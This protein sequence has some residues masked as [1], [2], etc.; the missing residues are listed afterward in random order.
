MSSPLKTRSKTRIKQHPNSI[1]YSVKAKGKPITSLAYPAQ[2][3]DSPLF[4]PGPGG[5][6]PGGLLPAVYSHSYPYY[7]LALYSIPAIRFVASEQA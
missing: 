3:L 6:G 2:D 7:A 5:L 4:K 1:T